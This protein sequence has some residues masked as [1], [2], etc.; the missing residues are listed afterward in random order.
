MSDFTEYAL[1]QPDLT[2]REPLWVTIGRADERP[3]STEPGEVI[4]LNYSKYHL[5][6]DTPHRHCQTIHINHPLRR[7]TRLTFIQMM[8]DNPTECCKHCMEL[9]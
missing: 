8:L 7:L 4:D 3:G 2:P 5:L 6:T 9:L 1:E